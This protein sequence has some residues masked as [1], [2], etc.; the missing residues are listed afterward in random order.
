MQRSEKRSLVHD[1]T[2]E[3]MW[4]QAIIDFIFPAGW[5]LRKP[6]CLNCQQ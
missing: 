5:Y 4:N 6:L 1:V 2:Y 3:F